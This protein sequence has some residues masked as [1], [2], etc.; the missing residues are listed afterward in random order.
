MR[1]S[2]LFPEAFLEIETSKIKLSNQTSKNNIEQ[3]F[4]FKYCRKN[5]KT[6]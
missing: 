3:N 1:C 5:I 4:K 2:T 6:R